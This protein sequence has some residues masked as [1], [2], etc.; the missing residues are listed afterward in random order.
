MKP[1]VVVETGVDHGIGS[2]I[3]CAALLRN[4]KEGEGGRYYGTEIRTEAGRLLSG[5]YA[6]IG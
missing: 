3:L 1:K 5:I 2:C 4:T 6:E